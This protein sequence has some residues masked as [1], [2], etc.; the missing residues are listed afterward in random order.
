MAVSNY[1]ELKAHIG[2]EIDLVYYGPRNDPVSVAI[3]CNDCSEV[4]L[5]FDKPEEDYANRKIRNAGE[6]A[7]IAGS[8]G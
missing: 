6:V 1:N 4:L 3:E 8:G 5:D 2:H 7:Q